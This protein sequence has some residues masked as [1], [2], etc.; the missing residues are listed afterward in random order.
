M[1]KAHDAQYNNYW[2]NLPSVDTPIVAAQLNRNE[3]TVNTIDDRV[4]SMDTTKANETDML[5]AVK[6]ISYDGTTGTFTITFFNGTTQTID[7]DI[8]KIAVN[9]SYDDDPTSPYYQHIIIELEDGTYKY[10]DLSALITEYEFANTSTIQITVNSGVVSADVI[11]GSITGS[12]LTPNYLADVTA[13]ANAA[14]NS[15]TAAGTSKLDAEAWAVGKRNGVDVPNTDPTYHNNAYY[16]SQQANVTSL[17]ALTDVDINSPQD[18]EALVYDANS[19]KY[20]NHLITLAD[21]GTVTI[22]SPTVDD[23]LKYDGTKWANSPESKGI[24]PRINV[25]VASGATVTATKGGETINGVMVSATSW[26]VDVTDYGTWTVT[27]VNGGTNTGTVT[28]DTVKEYSID[29]SSSVPEGSTVTPTD[30]IQTWLACAG[31]TDKAYTT[32]GEV[33]A[34]SVTLSA[35]M[36]DNNASDY[37]VRSTTWASDVCADSGA[38]TDIGVN[39][40]CA[41]KLISEATWLAAIVNSTYIETVLNVKVPIMT[42]NNTPSGTASA[43]YVYGV[44]YEAYRAFDG[45]TSTNWSASGEGN[46]PNWLQYKFP[47]A[48][49]IVACSITP[50]YTNSLTDVG[51]F[52]ILASNDNFSTS[53][54]L[55]NDTVPNGVNSLQTFKFSFSNSIEYDCWRI[56]V[57]SNYRN[58]VNALTSVYEVQFYGREDV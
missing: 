41:N 43:S 30:D 46:F 56:K 34:D 14:S 17:V 7:T 4:V 1:Q 32:I 47:T 5:L 27:A 3:Q 22:T 21:L 44:G 52:E 9:F 33:L 55:L 8:E 15:A 6:T 53:Q 11:D 49:R 57:S 26:Y 10:I 19:S 45:N 50:T 36:A 12:K 31:I 28:V 20:I 37:L 58:S 24:L 54:T 13:Q 18:G 2:Q 16:W 51:D 39:N 42:S 38:M 25:T 29:L 48:K 35:L 40:Y 23:V